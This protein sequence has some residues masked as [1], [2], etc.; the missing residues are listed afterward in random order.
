M[1]HYVISDL[2]LGMGRL[3]DDR[4]HPPEDFMYDARFKRYLDFIE[5]DGGDE[6]IINGD[7]IDF[8][9]LEPYAYHPGLFSED[10]HQLGWTQEDSKQ[11]LENCVAAN[12][13]KAFFDDLRSF[14]ANAKVR[15]CILMG[16][17]DPDL[18]W[19]EVQQR[20]RD[21]LGASDRSKLQFVPQSIARGSAHIEH[22]NQYCSPEN[23]FY[24]PA[25]IVQSVRRMAKSG[26][27]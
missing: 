27:N 19:P 7:W 1:K 23:R 24:N 17:H 11:K 5:N 18:F 6:L 26:W 10:G 16:N 15:L 25:N 21:L 9:Q 14:L 4:W 13:H 20:V 22:G 12:A 2:H 8:M 3:K